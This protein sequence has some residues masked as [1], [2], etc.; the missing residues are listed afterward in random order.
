MNEKTC[1]KLRKMALTIASEAKVHTGE[2]VPL[3]AYDEDAKKRH[4]YQ[5]QARGEQGELLFKADG[6]P[7]MTWVES[8]LGTITNAEISVRG[9]Y[10]ALK[11]KANVQSSSLI[12]P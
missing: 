2:D 3:T 8:S 11:A 6:E 4:K 12:N 1:K 7:E 5:V 9:I 10:R